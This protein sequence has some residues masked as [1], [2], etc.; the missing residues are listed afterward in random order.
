LRCSYPGER[1]RCE[2]GQVELGIDA[3]GLEGLMAKDIGHLFEAGASVDHGRS[4]SV[5]EDMGTQAGVTGHT[6]AH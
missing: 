5:P 6:H 4:G 3:S 1:D 2:G